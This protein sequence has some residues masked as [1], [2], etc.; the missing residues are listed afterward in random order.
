MIMYTIRVFFGWNYL[1][2]CIV[3]RTTLIKQWRVDH[4][5]TAR[6]LFPI[7]FKPKCS[8]TFPDSVKATLLIVESARL[9]INHAILLFLAVIRMG[10]IN[11]YQ[12]QTRGVRVRASR[13]RV[14]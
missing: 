2:D 1:I 14:H 6:D 9:Y 12:D 7:I 5:V 8:V 10:T 11:R 3:L 4:V 13:T